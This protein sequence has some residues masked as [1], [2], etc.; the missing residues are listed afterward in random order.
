LIN[1][2]QNIRICEKTQKFY[3]FNLV[4]CQ[5]KNNKSI[6]SRA[7]G[8]QAETIKQN[9]LKQ[10]GTVATTA[11]PT[12]TPPAKTTASMKAVAGDKK[13]YDLMESLNKKMEDMPERVGDATSSAFRNTQF[14][15]EFA[16][17]KTGVLTTE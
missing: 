4:I 5:A 7:F 12:T 13:L 6:G 15:F 16:T 2:I 14:T 9:N 3:V 11:T 17:D 10:G 1:T 8:L